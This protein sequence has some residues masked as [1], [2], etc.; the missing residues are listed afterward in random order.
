MAMMVSFSMPSAEQL[1]LPVRFLRNR[2]ARAI[3][4]V[5]ALVEPVATRRRFH[6]EPDH[7]GIGAFALHALAPLAAIGDAAMALADQADG[8]LGLAGLMRMQPFDEQ[9]LDLQRQAQQHPV[10][11]F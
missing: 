3:E 4:V 10:D 1:E 5:V 2:E 7:V 6:P 9:V 11:P 8:M